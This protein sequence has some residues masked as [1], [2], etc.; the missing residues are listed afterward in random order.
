MAGTGKETLMLKTMSCNDRSAK[1][2]NRSFLNTHSMIRFQSRI[3]INF[4]LIKK[5]SDKFNFIADLI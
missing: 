1:E 5:T 2:I 3:Q 4:V